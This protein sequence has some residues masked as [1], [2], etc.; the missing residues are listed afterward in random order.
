MRLISFILALITNTLIF[1]AGGAF[2]LAMALEQVHHRLT[3]DQLMWALS[4]PVN[5]Y[6]WIVR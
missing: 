3:P 2:A 1:W 4:W 6:H 5:C